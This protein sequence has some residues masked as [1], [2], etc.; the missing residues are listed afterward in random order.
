MFKQNKKGIFLPLF[1]FTTIFILGALFYVI[2][3][4]E[5]KREDLVGLK[6]ITLLK[7]YEEKE[8][9]L[10]YLD[11][12]IKYASKNAMKSL[13]NNGGYAKKNQ[14]KKI[15]RDILDPEEYIL[16]NTC[17]VLNLEEEFKEQIKE[18]VNE[19]LATYESSY[20]EID[21]EKLFGLSIYQKLG[22]IPEVVKANVTEGVYNS[23]YTE[24]IRTTKIDTLEP[25]QE[26][27]ILSLSTISYPVERSIESFIAFKPKL[28]IK[29]PDFSEYLSL[30]QSIE[31]NCI[32]KEVVQ[33]KTE[34]KAKFPTSEVK[35]SKDLLKISLKIKT[36]TIKLA[37]N[38]NKNIPTLVV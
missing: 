17:P 4:T 3:T 16:W 26:G 12:G 19:Y 1:V 31:Q 22:I 18:E 29:K 14:C 20:T 11:L 35:Q 33:C 32:K 38:T 2:N 37:I 28:K 8:K 36:G 6:A 21:F 7:T 9:T 24:N 5:S 23:I 34:L 25:V 10:D 15:E 13:A 27:Y 30:Y